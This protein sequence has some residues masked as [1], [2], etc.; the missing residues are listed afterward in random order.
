MKPMR[1]IFL[2]TSAA[3]PTVDRNPS[4]IIVD[5]GREYILLD[6]GEGTQKQIIRSGIGF[7]RLSRIF[8]SHLHGDHYYGV[9]P[10]LQTL[11]ILKR[12]KSLEIYAPQGF[13]NILSA[14]VEAAPMESPFEVRV[15][16]IKEKVSFRLKGYTVTMFPVVHGNI[17]TY[18]IAVR[19][20]DKPGKFDPQKSDEL[21]VP[22]ELRGLLQKGIPIKLPNGRVVHPQDV[23]GPPRRGKLLVYSS[24]TRP[25]RS[26]IEEGREADLLIHEATYADDLKERAEQA[27]HST[28]SEAIEVARACKAKALVLTHFSARYKEEDLARLEAEAKR[29]F[30][31]LVF[32]KDLMIYE[33]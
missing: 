31:P 23:M 25:C 1:V 29:M 17:P 9:F 6:A 4:S 12:R 7:G 3:V 2:G 19:E 8:I 11:S 21:G 15:F 26:L 27:G 5:L 33:L 22:L 30:N 18:G 16:E 28:I 13:H 32:A 20:D 14:I 24:D 10:L